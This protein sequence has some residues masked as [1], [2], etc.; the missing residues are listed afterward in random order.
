MKFTARVRLSYYAYV[1]VDAE[2]EDI[3]YDKAIRKAWRMQERGEGVWGEEPEV[4]DLTEGEM[5]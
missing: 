3:A 2:D 4:Y 1:E 5:Q